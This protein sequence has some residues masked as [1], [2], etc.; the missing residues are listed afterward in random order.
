MFCITPLPAE[1]TTR[2][3]FPDGFGRT[4]KT[5]LQKGRPFVWHGCLPLVKGWV[6]FACTTTDTLPATQIGF[7]LQEK[8][9][10]F[11]EK[12]APGQFPN[13]SFQCKDSM[14]LLSCPYLPTICSRRAAVGVWQSRCSR[15]VCQHI[16]VLREFVPLTLSAM[17]MWRSFALP[18]FTKRG[19]SSGG[20]SVN[21][22]RRS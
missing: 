6:R 17:L 22:A 5:L 12:T 13:S 20:A 8:D 7:I 3:P 16:S 10:R 11:F 14:Q 19:A 18:F 15:T 1:G 4:P 21:R 9:A 2:V